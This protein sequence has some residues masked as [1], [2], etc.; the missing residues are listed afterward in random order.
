MPVGI[1]RGTDDPHVP[2]AHADW[3]LAHIRTA[4]AHVYAGGHLPDTDVY[5]QIYE[6]LHAAA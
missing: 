1:W 6:W 4:Q 3:L 2:S 5:R